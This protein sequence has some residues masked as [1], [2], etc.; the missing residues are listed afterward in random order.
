MVTDV[1]RGEALAQIEAAPR[2]AVDTEF[3][4]ERRFWPKFFLLQIYAGGEDVWVFD[5]L[6]GRGL[7][8]LAEIMSSRPWI[9]HGGAQDLRIL[10]RVWGQV[11]DVV[12]DTQVAAGLL[13]DRYPAP[14]SALLKR[15]LDLDS[16]P[17]P[18]LSDWSRR[19]LS[20]RQLNYAGAD[21]AHLFH[22]WDALWQHAESL[23][24]QEQV[25]GACSTVRRQALA[26]PEPRNAWKQFD[27]V[28]YI[29]ERSLRS[30]RAIADWRLRRAMERDQSPYGILSDGMVVK[31]ARM[32]PSSL[33]QLG[34]DRRVPDR[35][36]RQ[37]GKTLVRLTEEAAASTD[38]LS[39]EVA[40]TG[41]PSWSR[42]LFLNLCFDIAARR[43]SWS[44]RLVIP[45]PL[46]I[47]WAVNPIQEREAFR[48]QLEP[49]RD[50]L[51]GD[52]WAQMASGEV[53]LAFQRNDVR[54]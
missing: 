21:V 38:V 17:Q 12:L 16:D 2:I 23:G 41:T 20:T 14:Y 30:L 42:W 13:A 32:Q 5:P 15:W 22:L 37:Y 8:G 9:V 26:E 49:W 40:R 36:V 50:S 24:R 43:E 47:A 35:V 54:I 29:D 27:A 39:D 51:V 7:S 25:L 18:T 28:S 1:N 46:R 53:S 34:S 31:L 44:A 52:L 3:H 4:A 45:D 11:P 6:E 48:S 19:P 10:K 33:A